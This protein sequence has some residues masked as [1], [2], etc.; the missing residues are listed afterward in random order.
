MA[1]DS[2]SRENSCVNFGRV[3][4]ELGE[5]KGDPVDDAEEEKDSQEETESIEEGGDG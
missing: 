3:G 4:D 1:V 2:G 5:E